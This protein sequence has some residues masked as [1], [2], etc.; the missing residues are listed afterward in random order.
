MAF[1]PTTQPKTCGVPQGLILGPLLFII[2]V[3]DIYN[4]SEL[5]FTVLYAYYTCLVIH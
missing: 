1:S 2:Y 3:N 4:V 5:L